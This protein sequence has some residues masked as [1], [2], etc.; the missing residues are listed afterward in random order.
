MLIDFRE[1]GR[2]GEREKGLETSVF[3]RSIDLLPLIHEVATQVCALT[4]NRTHK[5]S[6]YRTMLQAT[7]PHQPELFLLFLSF[8]QTEN[9]K[10]I[11]WHVYG[12]K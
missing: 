12:H 9:K 7:K 6:G 2:E 4:G 8:K 5:L 10:R 3:E 11:T 1:R